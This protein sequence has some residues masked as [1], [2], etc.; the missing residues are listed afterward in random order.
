MKK[1][2]S[3]LLKKQEELERK[4]LLVFTE[5]LTDHITKDH[6]KE[7]HVTNHVVKDHDP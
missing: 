4:I 6:V 2:Y 1:K 3:E 7:Q 5:L